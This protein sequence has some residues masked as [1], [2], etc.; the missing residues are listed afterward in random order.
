MEPIVWQ[1]GWS[2]HLIFAQTAAFQLNLKCFAGILPIIQS[3]RYQGLCTVRNTLLPVP[4]LIDP[5]S[6]ANACGLSLVTV[7][8]LF[9][10]H[11]TVAGGRGQ[12]LLACYCY[13]K[14]TL[15]QVFPFRKISIDSIYTHTYSVPFS[16][17]LAWPDWHLSAYWV[18]HLN[19]Y[20]NIIDIR[21]V[22]ST[23]D[24]CDCHKSWH[25]QRFI[26]PIYV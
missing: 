19:R 14:F 26:Y 5:K 12:S 20:S 21:C 9:I 24:C 17:F 6:F 7:L 3:Q 25:A 16:L 4:V 10:I 8:N 1:C 18:L 23:I 15:I 13:A 11:K 2:A 22:G